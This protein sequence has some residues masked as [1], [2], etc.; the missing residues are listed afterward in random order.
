MSIKLPPPLE[1]Y[2]ASENAR[3]TSAIARC[4]AANATVRDEGRSFK[5]IA[6]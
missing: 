4:F 2:F 6:E 3:D 5:G 1:F